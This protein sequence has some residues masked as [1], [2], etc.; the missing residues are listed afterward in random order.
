MRSIH[1]EAPCKNSC[2]RP[3]EIVDVDQAVS[4][5]GTGV[6]IDQVPLIF[7][8]YWQADPANKRGV[9][10]GLSI[11]KAIIDAHGGR[12][13]VETTV[14]H[15]STFFFTLPVAEATPA[16]KDAR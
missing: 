1:L 8:P 15:G 14:G 9:G 11:A 7:M 3:A 10:L 12:I 5:T 13:W 16:T 4:D 2:R 6:P